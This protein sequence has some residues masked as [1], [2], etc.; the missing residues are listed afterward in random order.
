MVSFVIVLIVNINGV[1]IL[2]LECQ[3]PVPSDPDGP[4][5]L[6]ITFQSMQSEGLNINVIGRFGSV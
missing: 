1:S 6:A 5:A 3:S 4:Y 2:E